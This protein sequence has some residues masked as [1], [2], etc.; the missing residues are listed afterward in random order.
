M[1]RG[2]F[3]AGLLQHRVERREL[4]SQVQGG[5]LDGTGHPP[6]HR[7]ILLGHPDHAESA[8][9]DLLEQFVAPDPAASPLGQ[10][11]LGCGLGFLQDLVHAGRRRFEEG[12]GTRGGRQQALH[13]LTKARIVRARPVQRRRPRAR[14]GQRQ[15][16]GKDL[17]G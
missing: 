7:L 10:Q 11:A 8:L 4:Q 13:L 5:R 2:F 6:A 17:I 12:P 14:V 1:D 16:G 3:G 15:R 9:A